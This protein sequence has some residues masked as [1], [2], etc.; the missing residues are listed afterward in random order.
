[1]FGRICV[2]FFLLSVS[3]HLHAQKFPDF[4]YISVET[5]D[6]SGVKDMFQ[7]S[8]F[9]RR[10]FTYAGYTVVSDNPAYWSD[11]VKKDSCS[12]LTARLKTHERI[13]GK[14]RTSLYMV[15]CKAD[16]VYQTEGKAMGPTAPQGFQNAAMVAMK[17]FQKDQEKAK[18]QK[19]KSDQQ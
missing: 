4:K 9:A 11:E 3:T 16:T 19:D 14:Y 6:Y 10:W 12:V 1:M 13:S 5:I 15:D 8:V 18:K 7:V 17:T 2:L